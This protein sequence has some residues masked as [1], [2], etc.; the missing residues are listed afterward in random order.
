MNLSD[1]FVP[2]PI[3]LAMRDMG[4]DEECFGYWENFDLTPKLILKQNHH[5]SSWVESNEEFKNMNYYTAHIGRSENCLAPTW[6]QFHVWLD[7]QAIQVPHIGIDFPIGYKQLLLNAFN[8]VK[9]GN[10]EP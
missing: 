3:A 1:Q 7:Q 5:K 10:N 2:H 8:E 4:F 6:F 9:N